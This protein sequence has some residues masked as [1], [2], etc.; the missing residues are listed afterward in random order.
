MNFTG[1]NREDK[2]IMKHAMKFLRFRY[3]D[4]DSQLLQKA[5]ENHNQNLT[6]ACFELDGSFRPLERMDASFKYMTIPDS[7]LLEVN[8]HIVS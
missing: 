2:P 6:N 7:F 3:P 5:F 4:A 8:C 1:P